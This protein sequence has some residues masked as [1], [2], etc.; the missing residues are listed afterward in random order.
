MSIPDLLRNHGRLLAV[1]G[2][3]GLLLLV[4]QTAL[5]GHFEL[6]AIREAIAGHRLGGVLLFIALFSLGNLM[7]IP[8]WVFL[9]AA[10]YAFGA[11]SGGWATYAAASVSCVL[12]FWVIRWLGGDALRRLK[13]PLALTLLRQLDTA[14]LRSVIG[15]RMLC[16]TLPALNAALALSGIRFRHYLLGTLLGLPLPIALYVLFFD[17]LAKWLGA[18]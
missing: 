6:A 2:F 7:L 10:V 11:W 13:N 4:R 17:H 5:G 18:N 3:V 16:Q 8:G 1:V 14:P 12:T 9:A 15:L